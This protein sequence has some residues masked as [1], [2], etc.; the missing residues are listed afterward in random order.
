MRKREKIDILKLNDII[1]LSNRILKIVF[2]FLC[3]IGLYAVTLIFKEWQIFRFFF[4]VLRILAPLFIG[5]LIAWILE[6]TVKYFHQRG[7][8]R[9]LA[10]SLIYIF[11]LSLFY[12]VITNLFPLILKQA[13]DLLTILPTILDSFTIWVNNFFDHFKNINIIDVFKI[14]TDMIDYTNSLIRSLT[15]EVPAITINLI[16]NLFSIIGVLVLSLMVGF[17]LLFDFNHLGKTIL[18]LLPVK[19]R[20]DVRGLIEEANGFLFGYLKGTLFISLMVFVS[21][22]IAFGII[23]LKAPLLLGL[24]CGIADIIPYIGPFIGGLPAVLLAFSYSFSTGIITIIALL[25]IQMIE[26]NFFRPLVMSKTMKLHPVNIII[27]ILVF[28]YLWG[29]IGMVI[30]TPLIA[31]LKSI[32][33]FIEKKYH[34]LKFIKESNSEG[35][36]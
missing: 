12:V 4:T 13:N 25:V 14:K 15:T 32:I 36:D 24:I 33:M 19:V 2:I 28:G 35:S 8:N 18:S 16:S 3:I 27:G 20:K 23:G 17:Y 10:S 30:A 5:L 9:I 22:T 26:N 1:N 21:S 34:I 31:M 29:V 7:T 6:P 11:I